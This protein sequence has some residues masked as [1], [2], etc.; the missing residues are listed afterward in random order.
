MF[1]GDMW[2]LWKNDTTYKHAVYKYNELNY[3]R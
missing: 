2:D 3:K 1:Y